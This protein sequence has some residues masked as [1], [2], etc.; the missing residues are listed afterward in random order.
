MKL[1]LIEDEI[2]FGE[3]LKQ[4]TEVNTEEDECILYKPES[5]EKTIQT[6]ED[7]FEEIQGIL[8]DY[9]L[10]GSTI[11]SLEAQSPEDEIRVKFRAAEVAQ[12]VRSSASNYN[13]ID[14]N[15]DAISH[16][17]PL[18]LISNDLSFFRRD[19][20]SHDLFDAVFEKRDFT[21]STT[22]KK[23]FEKIREFT[24]LYVEINKALPAIR[25][26][27][28]DDV[29]NLFLSLLNFPKKISSVLTNSIFNIK[30]SSLITGLD[31]SKFLY[32]DIIS[33]NGILMDA[34]LLRIRLGVHESSEGWEHFKSELLSQF[35]Y[36]G[37]L[38]DI[39]ERYWFLGLTDFWSNN[40]SSEYPIQLLTPEQ[41]VKLILSKYEYS[42]IPIVMDNENGITP[43]VYCSVTKVPLDQEFGLLIQESPEPFFWQDKLFISKAAF[44]SGEYLSFEFTI[45]NSELY[46]VEGD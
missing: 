28:L 23:T 5:W 36:Q 6:I 44:K 39:N 8:I 17:I 31:I 7:V 34:R 10:S 13:K 42:L 4:L 27:G 33:R 1:L 2:E 46:K 45:D 32:H 35:K 43:W 15:E 22:R 18:F 37:F 11:K 26:G 3:T 9:W 16:E 12:F 30:A 29:N 14:L 24:E 20:T 41:R 21:K 38:G 19:Q 40:I 25:A